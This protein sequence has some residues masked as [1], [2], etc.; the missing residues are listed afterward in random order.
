MKVFDRNI[1]LLVKHT[2]VTQKYISE[3]TEL[4]KSKDYMQPEQNTFLYFLP[5]WTAEILQLC[6]TAYIG[7]PLEMQRRFCLES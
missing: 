7:T 2:E 1:K 3:L 5:T 4:K 6:H